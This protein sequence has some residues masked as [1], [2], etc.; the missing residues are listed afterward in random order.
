MIRKIFLNIKLAVIISL[1]IFPCL[2]KGQFTDIYNY[3]SLH[4]L[5]SDSLNSEIGFS[6]NTFAASNSIK[7]EFV[8]AL[9]QKKY[10]S[11]DLKNNNPVTSVNYFGSEDN[12]CISFAHMPDSLFGYSQIG[13]KISVEN[14]FHG[15][16]IFSK[17]L[18]NLA[19]FGNKQYAG[20]T[21]DF[22]NTQLTFMKY[23][24]VKFGLFKQSVRDEDSFTIYFGLGLVKGQ[25]LNSVTL[26]T[27]NLFTEETGGSLDLN[28]QALYFSSDTSKKKFYHFN[29]FGACADLAFVYEDKKS[30]FLINC[31]LNDI[32]FMWWNK[33]SMI[34]PVDT[35]I[36]WDGVQLDS[37]IWG[38][39]TTYNAG[40]TQDSIM[41]IIYS[42]SKKTNFVKVIPEKINI[43]FTKRF[44]EKSLHITFGFSYLYHA[45]CPLPLIYTKGDYFFK[46]KIS[47][48]TQVAYGGYDKFQLGVG[49]SAMFSRH[50][51]L[52]LAAGN[53]LGFI[54]PDKTYAQSAS[55]RLM[56]IF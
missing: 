14:S 38:H 33:K 9:L 55:G 39:D 51:K 50:I 40:I 49:V 52:Q 43:A 45:N 21:A 20:K 25:T 15:D 3:Y 48:S 27:A 42:K 1:L 35:F 17:D 10:L 32:G 7:N 28:M 56:Y 41:K 46:N 26:D 16:V 31:S 13:Y 11:R 29:G 23:Q 24:Q 34:V 4:E 47:I 8:N 5:R 19:F 54:L 53:I 44:L 37:M 12:A 22:S 30:D 36:H 6:Y 2:V 18:Y